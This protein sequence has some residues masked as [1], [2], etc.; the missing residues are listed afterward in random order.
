MPFE[1]EASF[2]RTK[3]LKRLNHKGTKDTKE[4]RGDSG[5]RRTHQ[6]KFAKSQ[7]AGRRALDRLSTLDPAQ[8]AD[9]TQSDADNHEDHAGPE[10][11]HR[12]QSRADRVGIAVSLPP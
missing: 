11:K 10:R 6:S 8:V 5:I 1:M 4:K 3:I 9:N 7:C 2:E 12:E